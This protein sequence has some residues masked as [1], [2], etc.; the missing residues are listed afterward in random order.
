MVI[1]L[2]EMKPGQVGTVVQLSGGMGFLKRLEGMGIRVG[3]TVRKLGAGFWK[4]PQTI[5]VDG[6][7]FAVGYGMASK[8]FVEVTT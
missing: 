6:A 3:K 2:I 7:H 8:I 5:E 4:G 1:S